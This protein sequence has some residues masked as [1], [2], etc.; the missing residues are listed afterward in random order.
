VRRIAYERVVRTEGRPSAAPFGGHEPILSIDV[1]RSITAEDVVSTIAFLF[2][3]RGEPAVIPSDNGPEFI[4]RA[5][6]L[7]LEVSGAK[8]LYIESGSPW[9]NAYLET[10]IS[11]FGDELLKREMFADLLEA[12]VSVK[13]YRRHYS[14]HRPHSALGY[15]T[16]GQVCGGR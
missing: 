2:R 14:H 5:I 15:Q 1:E 13:D 3:Q 6:E 9:E 4:A 11:R 8:L 12:K 16:S 10:F 7:W